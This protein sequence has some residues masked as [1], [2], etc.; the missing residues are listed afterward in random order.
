LVAPAL[1]TLLLLLW[2]PL[3]LQEALGLQVEVHHWVEEE[4]GPL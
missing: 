3:R 2:R 1:L 4:E